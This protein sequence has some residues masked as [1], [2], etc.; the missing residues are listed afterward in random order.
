MNRPN[1]VFYFADQQRWDTMG[2]Y[3]QRLNVTPN[4][5][6][7]ALEGC[8]FDSAFTCQPVCGPARA[9]LQ[10]GLYATQTGCFRNDIELPDGIPTLAGLLSGAGYRT[11]Y[12]GKWHLASNADKGLLNQTRAVPEERRG[13]YADY[14]MAADCLELTSHGYNGYLFDE[15]NQRVDFTGFRADCVNAFAVDYVRAQDGG[16]PFFLFVSQLEPHHQNDRRRYEGPLGSKARF[17]DFD[18]PGDLEGTQGDWRENY[19]DYLG[20]CHSLDENVGRLVD[21]LRDRGLWDNTILIYTADH[22]S[23]FRTRN[24]EYKRS[25]HDGCTHIPLIIH[26]PGFNERRVV[27]ELV[28][29]MDLPATILDC[30]GVEKPASWQGRSLAPLSSGTAREWDETVFMQ[31]SESQVGRAIRTPQW[32]YSVRARDKDGWRDASSDEYTE[33]YLYDLASDPFERTNL[34]ADP[35]YSAVR[36]ELRGKLLDCMEQAGE[37]R[38]VIRPWT[39]EN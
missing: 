28:S 8:R 11:A 25:C 23:H 33:D 38:P 7:L 17:A 34:V 13:G 22:G 20:Q 15:R 27:K 35:A 24:G 30:A 21:A 29:L 31:I 26:G 1:I 9:C 36:G 6:S 10:S 12:V 4:L 5:D 39:P 32:K 18:V 16:Q 3:G 19:P 14:W 2:C 37:S